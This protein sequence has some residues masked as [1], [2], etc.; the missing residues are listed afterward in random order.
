MTKTMNV[1]SVTPCLIRNEFARFCYPVTQ[2]M[3]FVCLFVVFKIVITVSAL[4]HFAM[5]PT[6]L[7]I[8][9]K[10]EKCPFE[11]YWKT[12]LQRWVAPDVTLES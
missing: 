6:F 5:A 11:G 2:I 7:K 1:L 3:K 10:K 9:L 12:R 4:N 8:V